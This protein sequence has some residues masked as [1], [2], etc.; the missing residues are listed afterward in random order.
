MNAALARR[1]HRLVA[2]PEEHNDHHDGEQR[3]HHRPQNRW[4]ESEETHAIVGCKTLAPYWAPKLNVVELHS[5]L[6]AAR[7]RKFHLKGFECYE[8]LGSSK[9]AKMGMA[10]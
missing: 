3:N 5:G 1:P 8:T 6:R 2:R 7:R 4:H 10:L 9:D